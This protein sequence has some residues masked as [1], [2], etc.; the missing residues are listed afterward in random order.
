MPG[1]NKLA[2]IPP[3][4]EYICLKKTALR[5]DLLYFISIFT[6]LSF[7]FFFLSSSP[8]P[9]S[10]DDRDV[11]VVV[12][13][14]S[15]LLASAS[16]I[17]LAASS[18]LVFF[19]SARCIPSMD[20]SALASRSRHHPTSS[21]TSSLCVLAEVSAASS[22][23]R[24]TRHVSSSLASID[25][26]DSVSFS[27]LDAPSYLFLTSEYRVSS[28]RMVASASLS[29]DVSVDTVPSNDAMVRASSS[30]SA[31]LPVAISTLTCS[32]LRYS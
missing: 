22:S 16:S 19:F 31:S 24:V 27:F 2:T 15:P 13:S 11:V 20:R 12:A 8:R 7:P 17:S 18:K 29:F 28:Y 21:S 25:H 5:N 1:N 9:P 10:P 32:R 23:F 4:A 3:T 26:R 30:R 14:P 6:G